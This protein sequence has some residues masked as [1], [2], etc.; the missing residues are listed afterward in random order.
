MKCGWWYRI[1]EN[2]N[3]VY[4]ILRDSFHEAVAYKRKLL[5]QL[6]YP[7]LL[8]EVPHIVFSSMQYWRR[9]SLRFSKRERNSP[10][11]IQSLDTLT[12][13]YSPALS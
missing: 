13:K 10:K 5:D 9:N 8:N 4:A 2:E 1:L 6:I 11:I 7:H 12:Q 3:A